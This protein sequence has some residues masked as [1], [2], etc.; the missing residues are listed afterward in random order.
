MVSCHGGN[1]QPPRTSR[2][3]QLWQRLLGW[4]VSKSGRLRRG[5][6]PTGGATAAGGCQ[7]WLSSSSF[8]LALV[9]TIQVWLMVLFLVYAAI[10]AVVRPG[11]RRCPRALKA[12]PVA[13][14]QSPFMMS[15]PWSALAARPRHRSPISVPD[16]KP[17]R[18]GAGPP[19]E[20]QARG[21]VSSWASGR[22]APGHPTSIRWNRAP[23]A[24]RTD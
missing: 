16:Q 3:R 23:R 11:T 24:C 20:T 5:N 7:C 9:L 12:A 2:W 14:S 1:A 4:P 18:R 8:S 6:E 22:E 17:R 21:S 19:V 10:H 13:R 15:A